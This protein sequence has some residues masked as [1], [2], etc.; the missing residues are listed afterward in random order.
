M[1][2]FLLLTSL[3]LSANTLAQTDV[4]LN[5]NHLLGDQPFT[6]NTAVSAADGYDIS[7]SRVEYYMSDIVLT[8]DGGQ[9]T[10]FGDMTLLVDAASTETLLIGNV[11]VNQL[12]N[13]SFS[14]GVLED[15]N[16]LDPSSYDEFHP[17]ANQAPSMH[18]G[19]AFGYKF[20]C[21]EGMAGPQLDNLVEIHAL[22]D[23]NY[24]SQSH[25]LNVESVSGVVNITLDADYLNLTYNLDMSQGLEEHGVVN[26][27]VD[28]LLNMRS[29]VFST[30]AYLG[31]TNFDDLNLRLFP[32]PARDEVT[33]MPLSEDTFELNILNLNGKMV[34]S[35]S[36][37]NGTK[38]M[39]VSDFAPG[40]YFVTYIQGTVVSTSKLV[41][42]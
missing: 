23:E 38:T 39:S 5:I 16:H 37:I 10:S 11:N 21:F 4:Y 34:R 2:F 8:H 22:G 13:I 41:V 12:E 18:W 25:E 7:L 24:M 1:R 17:L 15:L 29:L 28:I 30:D 6:L 31:T 32:N 42:K 3:F 35:F 9:T 40:I 26:S 14:I 36:N 20:L 19:W 33:F 27:A